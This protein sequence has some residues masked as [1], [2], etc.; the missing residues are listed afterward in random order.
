MGAHEGTPLKAV[1]PE[2]FVDVSGVHNSTHHSFEKTNVEFCKIGVR[3]IG[4]H[5]MEVALETLALA[6]EET[7][8]EF[9]GV[10]WDHG[11][12]DA[13]E[14]DVGISENRHDSAIPG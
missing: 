14:A 4:F 8:G 12:W 11:S 6:L 5:R 7:L 3:C 13:N 2:S 9:L 1:V 10:V